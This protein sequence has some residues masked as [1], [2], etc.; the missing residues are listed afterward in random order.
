MS[1]K[2]GS[3]RNKLFLKV[4]KAPLAARKYVLKEPQSTFYA[5]GLP[6]LSLDDFGNGKFSNLSSWL[7]I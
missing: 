3:T 5:K 2:M 4:T 6:N 7:N 1:E